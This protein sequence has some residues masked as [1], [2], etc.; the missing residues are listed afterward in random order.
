MNLKESKL[1]DIIQ[2]IENKKKFIKELEDKYNEEVPVYKTN[3]FSSAKKSSPAGKNSNKYYYS[4]NVSKYP[5]INTLSNERYGVKS[6]EQ[7]LSVIKVYP[8][9]ENRVRDRSPNANP[10][11]KQKNSFKSRFDGYKAPNKADKKKAKK[12]EKK[13]H[14][15]LNSWEQE[16]VA[17]HH[18]DIKEELSG[19][20]SV[21]DKRISKEEGSVARRLL[22]SM[23]KMIGADQ[24]D[25]D[26]DDSSDDFHEAAVNNIER[27]NQDSSCSRPR[28]ASRPYSPPFSQF[29]K[30]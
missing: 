1:K 13:S 15:Y 5:T 2:N 28:F 21:S 16:I 22:E 20:E 24:N 17:A 23:S 9:N 18:D 25:T 29:S 14:S 4:P 8:P 7:V 30:D 26:E 10:P 6:E 11:A 27:F 19:D 12:L 3:E